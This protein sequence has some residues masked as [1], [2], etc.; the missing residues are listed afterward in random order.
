MDNKE[1]EEVNILLTR[2][3]IS[4][5]S[6]ISKGKVISYSISSKIVKEIGFLAHN[7]VNNS[8]A[9][10][11]GQ[12]LSAGV[13][14]C[15]SYRNLDEKKNIE[16]EVIGIDIITGE[17]LFKRKYKAIKGSSLLDTIDR[18]SLEVGELVSGRILSLGELEINVINTTNSYELF[19]NGMLE[20][21]IPPKFK[22]KLPSGIPFI[23]SMRKYQE[24]IEVFNTNVTLV[25][26]EKMVFFIIPLEL[27]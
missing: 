21:R 17:I 24:G 12:K 26:E 3:L 27:L 20:T 10:S 7:K 4:Y 8:L 18:L 5:L 9:I 13:V 2:S 22:K 1:N 23:L 11:I 14:I 6:K 19:I 25:K 16:I 15:G